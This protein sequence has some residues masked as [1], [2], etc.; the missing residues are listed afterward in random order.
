MK[1]T[2]EQARKLLENPLHKH[3]LSS[4]REHESALRVFTEELSEAELEK[5]SYW[6]SLQNTMKKRVASGKHERVCDF[7]R[8]PLPV[9][10]LTDSII[11][12]F[13]KVFDG[14]N[15]YFNIQGDRDVTRLEKWVK[16]KNLERWIEETASEV[17]KNKPCSFVVV[18]R[19]NNDDPYYFLVDS[20]RIIDA[21]EKE[22]GNGKLEYRY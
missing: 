7:I 21:K 8:Y 14:K 22:G 10:Q 17:F 16:N 2:N 13:N 9:Q 18:D 4:V 5:E 3:E 19:S 20:K 6:N 11:G 12:D 15:K 1:L